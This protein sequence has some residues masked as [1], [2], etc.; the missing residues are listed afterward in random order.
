[1]FEYGQVHEGEYEDALSSRG[2]AAEFLG[3]RLS[4]RFEAPEPLGERLSERSK[5]PEPLGNLLE[6]E[7]PGDLENGCSHRGRRRS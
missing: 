6:D 1:M 7:P 3:E 5:P 4:E 2:T